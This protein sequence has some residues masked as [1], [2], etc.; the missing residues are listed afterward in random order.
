MSKFH[1]DQDITKAES[2]PAK[3]YRDESVFNRIENIF[4]KTWQWVGD[5]NTLVPFS[6]NPFIYIEN[7]IMEPLLLVRNNLIRYVAFLMFVLIEGT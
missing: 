3:F 4:E 2:L 5:S 7:F 6:H 1:I